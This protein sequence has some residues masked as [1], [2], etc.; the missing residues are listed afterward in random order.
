M[1]PRGPELVEYINLTDR[2]GCDVIL[3]DKCTRQSTSTE[4][5]WVFLQHR[6]AS[7]IPTVTDVIVKENQK[8]A[9]RPLLQIHF[10]SLTG[11]MLPWSIS[12]LLLLWDFG[13]N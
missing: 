11:V 12:Y 2:N 7:M 1:K 5:T 4:S 8:T 6:E 13:P 3:G 9:A 10:F